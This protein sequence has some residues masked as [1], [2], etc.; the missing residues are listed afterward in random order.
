MRIAFDPAAND[1]LDHVFAWIAI[2]NVPAAYETMIRIE[3]LIA[4][5]QMAGLAEMGRPGLIEGTRE[6][7]EPPYIIVYQVIESREEI[8]IVSVIHSA[9]NR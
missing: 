3:E 8:L 6:L 9:Q 4:R 2:D 7:I 1:D 5:L